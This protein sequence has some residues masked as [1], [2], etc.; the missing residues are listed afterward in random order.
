MHSAETNFEPG[1]KMIMKIHARQFIAMGISLL[2]VLSMITCSLGEQTTWDCPECGRKG[3]TGNYCGGCAHPAPWIEKATGVTITTEVLPTSTPTPEPTQTPRPTPTPTPKPTATPIPDVKVEALP[4]MFSEL[5]SM[6]ENVFNDALYWDVKS[7]PLTLSEFPVL[8]YGW[9]EIVRLY[10]NMKYSYKRQNG[11]YYITLSIPD[12][13]LKNIGDFPENNIWISVMNGNHGKGFALEKIDNNNY[14]IDE[15]VVQQ[16]G[17]KLG[18][19]S[20][21]K[22]QSSHN[23]NIWLH[24]EITK[25]RS[26][27]TCEFQR[28]RTDDVSYSIAWGSYG[29]SLIEITM[30]RYKWIKINQSKPGQLAYIVSH[31]MRQSTVLYYDSKSFKLN[32][33]DNV[34]LEEWK[35]YDLVQ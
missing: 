34:G 23:W 3:N 5:D 17:G 14:S 2:L 8:P 30:T 20:I 27:M 16:N 12:K 18:D 35:K 21:S 28:E 26:Y 13:L 31:K 22:Y 24:M 33:V 25:E 6:I 11:K 4:I 15:A 10:K 9:N 7:A 1:E 19:V 32:K 29:D